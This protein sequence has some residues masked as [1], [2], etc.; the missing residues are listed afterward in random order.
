MISDGALVRA[1]SSM[2]LVSEEEFITFETFAKTCAER[3]KL[4]LSSKE[5]QRLFDDLTQQSGRM[6]FQQ[7]IR[8][9]AKH[10]FMKGGL[11]YFPYF[12]DDIDKVKTRWL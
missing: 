12:L 7:F 9:V 10:A 5:L 2:A 3:L 1:T 11:L 4:D 8:S 6:S